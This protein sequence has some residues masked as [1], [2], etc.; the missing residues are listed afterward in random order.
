MTPPRTSDNAPSL[1]VVASEYLRAQAPSTPRILDSVPIAV[2]GAK[3]IAHHSASPRMPGVPSRMEASSG[4]I[5]AAL[6]QMQE[7]PERRSCAGRR[8][9]LVRSRR[10]PG[11]SRDARS[12]REDARPKHAADPYR[13]YRERTQLPMPRRCRWDISTVT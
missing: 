11:T 10:L 7:R 2:A 5:A 3:A 13:L 12:S 4:G 8:L 9:D 1:L 6:R